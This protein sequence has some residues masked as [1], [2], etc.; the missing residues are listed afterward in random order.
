MNQQTHFWS[1]KNKDQRRLENDQE[2]KRQEDVG[3][4]RSESIAAHT[5]LDVAGRK[6]FVGLAHSMPAFIRHTKNLLY[7]K[8]V[9]GR[10]KPNAG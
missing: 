2:K 3:K 1:F 4:D 8:W 5:H 9:K 7:T 10:T 6:G